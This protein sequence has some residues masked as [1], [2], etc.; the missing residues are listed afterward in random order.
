M[1]AF[2]AKVTDYD[3]WR[4]LR[5]DCG[6]V[7]KA[8]KISSRRASKEIGISYQTVLDFE[9]GLYLPHEATWS[10]IRDWVAVKRIQLDAQHNTL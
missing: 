6:E 9:R 7:R 10:S 2:L 8:L 3:P 1:K 4:D 5:K